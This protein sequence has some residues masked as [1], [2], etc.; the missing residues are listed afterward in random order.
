[1]TDQIRYYRTSPALGEPVID[2]RV[3]EVGNVAVAYTNETRAVVTLLRLIADDMEQ[4]AAAALQAADGRGSMSELKEL[5]DLQREYIEKRNHCFTLINRQTQNLLNS[6]PSP[7]TIQAASEREDQ[8]R[9][10][11]AGW[12]KRIDAIQRRLDDLIGVTDE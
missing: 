6:M 7:Y 5:R 10:E 2:L 1:M 4:D 8:L 11:A 9:E 12:Q 3:D